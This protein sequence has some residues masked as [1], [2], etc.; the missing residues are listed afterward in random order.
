MSM[1]QTAGWV[2][3][4]DKITT[5]QTCGAEMSVGMYARKLSLYQT[6]ALKK[7]MELY[8]E[9]TVYTHLNTC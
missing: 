8:F 6:L 7:D 3:I 5:L 9:L 4:S 2:Y 1:V